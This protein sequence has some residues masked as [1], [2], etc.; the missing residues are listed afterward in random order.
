MAK[1]SLL[2]GTAILVGAG[3]LNRVLGFAYQILIIDL[4]GAKGIGLYNM[5]FPVYILAIVIASAGIPLAVSKFVAAEAGR[6]NPAGARRILRLALFF[7]TGTAALSTIGLVWAVP[8]LRSYVFPNPEAYIVFRALLPGIILIS[9][10]SVFRGYFQG[11]MEMTPTAITMVTEQIVR[12]VCGLSLAGFFLRYGLAYA[13][14]GSAIGAIFGE[15][16]GLAAILILYYRHSAKLPPIPLGGLRG[17]GVLLKAMLFFSVPVTL[18]RIIATLILTLEASIIPRQLLLAGCTLEQATVM[19]GQ[20][21]GMALPIMAIPSIVT[22][23]LATTMVPAV[24]E[25]SSARQQ[26]ILGERIVESL[27]ITFCIGLPA[28]VT[29]LLLPSQLTGLLFHNL[30]AGQALQVLAFGGLFYYLQQTTT[31][32]LQGLGRADLPLRNLVA[33]SILELAGL[34]V[35]VRIPGMGLRGAAWAINISFVIV[36]VTNLI[37]IA[38]LVAFVFPVRELLVKPAL[39]SAAMGGIMFCTFHWLSFILKNGSLATVGALLISWS[40]Y[41]A[42]LLITGLLKLEYFTKRSWFR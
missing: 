11:L 23:S 8:Y 42:F 30:Q 15:F 40:A 22:A 2:V 28:V 37:C 41:L 20:L 13:A 17:S 5:V 39:A 12:V 14:M 29:F 35:L 26:R 7:I 27:K 24:S 10:C 4:I 21:T 25:A 18:S 32:I 9:I 34:L 33:A 38:R 19:F 6:R 31:G 3:L 36:A 1:Q 16:A